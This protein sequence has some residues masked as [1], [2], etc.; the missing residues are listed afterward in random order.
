ML[1]DVI[2]DEIAVIGMMNDKDIDGYLSFVAPK[3]KRIICT[4]VNNSRAI[5]AF[6]LSKYAKKY[7]DD[8]QVIENPRIAVKEKGITLICGS[9][10]LLREIID[11]I[12]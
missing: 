1:A 3:C 10:Y 2:N 12:S 9:F 7:C 5:S 4:N 6:E 11:L 8:V